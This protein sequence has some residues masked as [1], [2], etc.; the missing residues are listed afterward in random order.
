[1][2]FVACSRP[3]IQPGLLKAIATFHRF[4]VE[5]SHPDFDFARQIGP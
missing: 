4:P 1:M 3:S 2:P 5:T